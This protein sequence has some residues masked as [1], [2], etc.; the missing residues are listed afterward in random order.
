MAAALAFLA[1]AFIT[2]QR[3]PAGVSGAGP[4]PLRAGLPVLGGEHSVAPASHVQV[5]RVDA[6]VLI[7]GRGAPVKD[8]SVVFSDA[9]EILYAGPRDNIPR[10]LTADITVAVPAVMPGL[11]DCH[12]HFG[13]P[14][15][16]PGSPFKLDGPM[17]ASAF[18]DN[19]VRFYDAVKAL[20]DA[21]AMGVTSVREVGGPFGQALREL[22][23]RG[24]VDGPHFH[25]S[26]RAIGM[27]GGHSD[28]HTIPSEVFLW[29]D[30][31]HDT[32][33]TTCNGVPECLKRVRENLRMQA[34]AI[35]VMTTGGAMSDFDDETTAEL[36]NAEV[37]AITAEAKRSRR[38][39]AAH[40]HGAPGIQSAIDNGVTSVEHGTW[41]TPEQA[42][43]IIAKG[44]MVYTPTAVAMQEFWNA[45]ERPPQFD[46]YQWQKGQMLLRQHSR[47]VQMAISKKVPIVVGTDCPMNC[48]QAGA[49]VNY[50]HQLGMSALEAI[51]AGTAEAPR[52]MGTWGL[53]P[54][55]G[56]LKAGYDADLIALAVSP[57]V[58]L[59]VLKRGADITHVWRGGKLVKLPRAEL[60]VRSS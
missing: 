31:Q 57:L 19:Y 12:T 3:V 35:K 18:P 44:Y 48:S 60:T 42:D 14:Y 25:Y 49:E 1:G 39:V 2:V 11:W 50:L 10:N 47:T 58:D 16:V 34:D 8:G 23:R 29:M 54:K 41:M 27:T 43:A 36:S 9:G 53:M 51:A 56:Q 37:A 5:T 20:Q 46:E 21:L 40:A 28:E 17:S 30:S 7:P 24:G 22:L 26:G 4:L 55:S 45:T 38:A 59:E 13:G 32:T 6:Q 15:K 33:G 52:C